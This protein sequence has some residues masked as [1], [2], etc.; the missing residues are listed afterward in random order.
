MKS[1]L[2]GFLLVAAAF[3][4][5]APEL[6]SQS[7]IADLVRKADEKTTM[8][9]AAIKN[10]QAI[11]PDA[12]PVDSLEAAKTSHEII[13][14]IL[15]SGASG[16][17]LVGLVA[18]LDD[19]SLNASRGTTNLLREAIKHPDQRTMGSILVLSASSTDC[20]DISELLLH[21]TLRYIHA[22]ETILDAVLKATDRPKSQPAT[23]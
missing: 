5:N 4:Q 21:T 16:Y 11:S 14:T 17:G 3:A 19:M 22:E 12:V 2:I 1:L 6:P 15:N 13:K 7:E 20:N 10:A 23:H 9:E 18:T 8:Y